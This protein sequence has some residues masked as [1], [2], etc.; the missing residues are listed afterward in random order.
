MP[1]TADGRTLILTPPPGAVGLIGDPTDWQRR[2]PI[3]VQPG[4]PLRLTLPQNAWMEYAWVDAAGQPFADPEGLPTV[5]PWFPYARAAEVGEWAEHPLW[6]GPAPESGTTHRLSWDGTVFP[7]RRRASVYLPRG[8]QPGASLPV[9]YVQD[10]VAFQRIGRLA[11][12]LE[13]AVA[14]GLARPAALVFVEPADREAEYYLNGDYLTFLTDEVMPRVEGDLADW[15]TP[16]RATERGLWGASLGGL[17]SL[18]LG[19][20][21]PDLFSRV[22][23]HSGA[24]IARPDARTPQGDIDVMTAGEWLRQQ[25]EANPPRHLTVSLDTGLLEWLTA[26]NRRM[27]AALMDGGVDHQY[28]EYPGG[29]NWVTWR[30]ALMEALL[31]QLQG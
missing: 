7:G 6:Q 21:H 2:D 14:A 29:H 12:A 17:I 19:A 8:V 25:L 18:H 16:L 10:G 5:N 3:A 24:F 28:R 30:Q 15:G 26:P 31:F 27:A 23:S 11:E 4:Q 9:F 22:V 1:A 20:A 13:R